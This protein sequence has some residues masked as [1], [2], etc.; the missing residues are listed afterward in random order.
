MSQLHIGSNS[1]EPKKPLN[2]W[3]QKIIKRLRMEIWIAAFAFQFS[4]FPQSGHK[5]VT[6][7]WQKNKNKQKNQTT[8]ILSSGNQKGW[9]HPEADEKLVVKSVPTP[10]A[11]RG[12][13]HWEAC[14]GSL[15]LWVP[16]WWLLPSNNK[17][18]QH[19]LNWST[20]LN[21]VFS[22]LSL[23]VWAIAKLQPF[24]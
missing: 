14:R 8:Q 23:V 3:W 15:L 5:K 4:H 11:A 22:H 17:H 10:A 19:Q 7:P 9:R 20:D 12:T 18:M 16:V 24:M 13:R 1:R 21:K 6:Q 2:C